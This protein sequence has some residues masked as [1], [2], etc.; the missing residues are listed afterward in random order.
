MQLAIVIDDIA[1]TLLEV[2]QLGVTCAAISAL[3]VCLKVIT[4]DT[5]SIA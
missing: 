2:V 1:L 3:A 4:I 5:N